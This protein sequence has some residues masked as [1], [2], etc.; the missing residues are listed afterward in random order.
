MQYYNGENIIL[1]FTIFS[2][3]GW[4]AETIYCFIIDKKFTYRG[5]LYGPVCPIYGTGALIVIFILNPV[6]NNIVLLF[7]FGVILTSS[8]EYITSYVMEKIFNMKWWDYSDHKFNING[9]VCLLNSTLFGLLSI[10]LMKFIEPMVVY[11]IN[12]I[13]KDYAFKLSKLIFN[14]FVIDSILTIAHLLNLKEKIKNLKYIKKEL[15]N[16][17][18]VLDSYTK[19]ELQKIKDEFESKEIKNLIQK[20]D[21]NIEES[22]GY[23]RII[24]TYSNL[25]YKYDKN[26]LDILKDRLKK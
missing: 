8:L 23:K 15:E 17:G 26:L 25:K 16:L 21:R 24:N 9:R 6:R 18:V 10:I 3:L 13:P 5:F 14:I 4:L 22:Y 7:L 11:F 19:E 2:F 20:L 12:E 1:Y